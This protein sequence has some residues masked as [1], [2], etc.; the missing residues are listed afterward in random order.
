MKNI[1]AEI[2]ILGAIL[3]N[4]KHFPSCLETISEWDFYLKKHFL[5]FRN[6]KELYADGK[7]INLI[8]LINHIGKEDILKAGGIS[9][10]SNLIEGGRNLDL[11]AYLELVKKCSTK[12]KLK[13][14]LE[15]GLKALAKGEEDFDKIKDGIYKDLEEGLDVKKEVLEDKKLIFKTL[16]EIENRYKK[17]GEVLGMATGYTKLDRLLN[18]FKKGELVIL[19]GRPGMGKTVTALNL[20]DGLADNGNKVLLNELEMTEEAIGMRRLSYRT[21][22]K[23]IAIQNGKLTDEEFIKIT[24]EYNKLA[25]RGN[26]YTDCSYNQSLLTIMTRA[27]VIKETKGLD[28]LIIDYL[29]LMEMQVKDTKANAVG[30]I[31]R[32]LKILAKKLDINIILLCQLSRNVEGRVDKRPMLSDLRDSGSIEQDADIVIFTYRDSY[33]KREVTEETIELIVAKNRNGKDGVV[34]MRYYGEWQK[35]A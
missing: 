24:N 25:I 18:G 21:N 15:N 27:K 14:S 6:M 13:A 35:I 29:G 10:I 28:V 16:E 26:V 20:M 8:N 33:Y 22:I 12:R 19:A 1:E 2:E 30:E 32:G 9:Y 34:K 7:R 17:G 3:N 23:S 11:K 5:I 31:T 4:D